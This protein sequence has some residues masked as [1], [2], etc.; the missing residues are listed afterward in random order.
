MFENGPPM[1]FYSLCSKPKLIKNNFETDDSINN[2]RCCRQ[3]FRVSKIKSNQIFFYEYYTLFS[4][5]YVCLD[6]VFKLVQ[7]EKMK[8]DE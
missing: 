2:I 3:F 6:F 7:E 8:C 4:M 5:F 1:E